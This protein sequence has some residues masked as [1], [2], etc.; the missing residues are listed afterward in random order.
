MEDTT[1]LNTAVS[2]T[3]AIISLLGPVGKT[4]GEFPFPGYYSALFPM[5]RQHSVA[6]IL[7]M[8]TVS[9]EDVGD[10][11]S[12]LRGLMVGGVRYG[13]AA[14]YRTILRIAA[15]FQQE[16]EGLDWTIF[17]LGMVQGGHDGESWKQDRD[18]RVFAGP[19]GE[20]GWTWKIRRGALAKW[21]VDRIEDRDTIPGGK[22]PA[23]SCHK[24]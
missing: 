21:L 11:S 4:S 20:A 10:K 16:A 15:V 9:I 12:L 23:L 7:A 17:R 2:S 8:G 19:V 1:R 24:E 22:M 6:R 13:F 3:S 14:A 18:D 5:M